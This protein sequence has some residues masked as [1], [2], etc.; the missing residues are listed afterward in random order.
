MT[1]LSVDGHYGRTVGLDL[2]QA[3]GALWFDVDESLALTPGATLRLFVVIGEHR[4]DRR[5][6]AGS[7]TCPRCRHGLA[8]T[9]DMQRNTRFSY[10]R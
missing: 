6:A 2:C 3:C 1:R 7:P 4:G 9:S 8:L 10:W 5:A